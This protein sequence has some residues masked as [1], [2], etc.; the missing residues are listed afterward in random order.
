VSTLLHATVYVFLRNLLNVLVQTANKMELQKK[1]NLPVIL[2]VLTL[3]Y[4]S[5]KTGINML[6]YLPILLAS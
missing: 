1:K 6:I 2:A 5:L 4:L 3:F